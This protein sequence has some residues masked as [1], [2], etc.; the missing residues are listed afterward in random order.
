M[1]F[2]VKNNISNQN[3]NDLFFLFLKILFPLRDSPFR[4]E[5]QKLGF[6]DQYSCN[7]ELEQSLD[8]EYKDF[9]VIEIIA[10]DG[11]NP[12]KSD[13]MTLQIKVCFNMVT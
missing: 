2:T 11:G 6:D 1:I 4:L 3:I 12:S 10:R 7:L 9:Y 13:K 5:Q 8:R